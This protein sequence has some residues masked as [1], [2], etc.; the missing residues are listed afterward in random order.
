MA[1]IKKSVRSSMLQLGSSEESGVIKS[2]LLNADEQRLSALEQFGS[3][4]EVKAAITTL[5]AYTYNNGTDGVGATITITAN[6]DLA[7]SNSDGYTLV[8]TDRVF[9]D[10]AISGSTDVQAGI[11]TIVQG[12]AGQTV[13]TR[14]T[15]A[16]AD[17]DFLINKSV[18]I[19]NGTIHQGSIYSVNSGSNPDIGTDNIT[20]QKTSSAVTLS[21]AQVLAAVESESGRDMSADGSKLDGIEA[22]ATGDQTGAEIK[23]AYE[24]EADTNAFSDADKSK[25]DGIESGATANTAGD[26]ISIDSGE[27]SIQLA[28][29][30]APTLT[31]SGATTSKFDVT[32]TAVGIGGIDAADNFD[33]SN[34]NGDNK[35]YFSHQV[36]GSNWYVLYYNT[37][38][39]SWRVADT[40]TDPSTFTN[41]AA[42]GVTND[43]LISSSG[44]GYD[45]LADIP[46]TWQADDTLRIPDE[47]VGSLSPNATISYT[48]GSDSSNLEFDSGRLKIASDI[49]SKLSNIEEN[50]TA[51][52][53][54]A[55]ILTAL[56][57]ET[58]RNYNDDAD[59]LDGIETLA[60]VTDTDNVEAAGAL[61]DSEVTNLDQV[62]NFDSAD[63][64]TAAQGSLADSAMQQ[65]DLDTKQDELVAGTFITLDSASTTAITVTSNDGAVSDGDLLGTSSGSTW[66]RI[67]INDFPNIRFSETFTVGQVYRF[68]D[69]GN[70]VWEFELGS[71]AGGGGSTQSYIQLV[72]ASQPKFNGQLNQ[73]S[74]GAAN[75]LQ[76]FGD[77]SGS[78][79]G[80]GNIVKVA[81]TGEIDVN[82]LDEDDMTSDSATHVPTQQS[83]KAYVDSLDS[84]LQSTSDGQGADRIGVD[85]NGTNYTNPNGSVGG[86][87]SGIDT[88]IGSVSAVA[89]AAA[90]AGAVFTISSSAS[91][92][93]TAGQEIVYTATSVEDVMWSMTD[94]D[95]T[96][97]EIDRISGE[98]SG[99]CPSA[100]T[101]DIEIFASNLKTLRIVSKTVTFTI[102]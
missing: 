30:T 84:A 51:D 83:V 57:S 15:D 76:D 77:I 25:L 66:G 80:S 3:F 69:S 56:E 96:G 11:Y 19:A 1:T 46:S 65:A 44:E 97:F 98:L 39:G 40:T 58:G 42:T 23:L 32:Y 43:E 100:G 87:L 52:Q 2:P 21:D 90:V 72:P 48:A 81:G 79:D 67:D 26:G 101:Y 86:H 73:G 47:G 68:T 45:T 6:G 5:P 63:Y 22:G 71:I 28:G 34:P 99:T 94:T 102:S 91:G 82:V 14:A 4:T 7:S 36:D 24:A 75:H 18:Y 16:D 59:K 20:F 62:K 10:S 27:I 85:F 13:F 64:A 92:S 31:L 53:T 33:T 93:G 95:T 50:A 89:N 55:E 35:I 88:A 70:D 49:V 17:S 41:D 61:M 60:D 9:I 37:S 29:Q 54:G 8:D 38:S 12:G 74:G 78:W